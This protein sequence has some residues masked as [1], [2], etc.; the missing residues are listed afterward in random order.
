MINYALEDADGN[1]FNI[2]GEAI[3]NPTRES[4]FIP[5]FKFRRDIDLIE[6]TY[7]PGAVLMNTPRLKSCDLAIEYTRANPDSG[8][9]RTVENEL[10][11]WL[12]KTKYLVDL[13]SE[14]KTRV[15][16]DASTI[17]FRDGSLFHAARCNVSFKQLEPFWILETEFTDLDSGTD[18]IFEVTNNGSLDT[19]I[20]F[21]LDTAILCPSFII[22]NLTTGIGIAIE[23][24]SFGVG[25]LDT[26]IIDN[27][28]G[29]V[30]LEYILRMANI[31]QGTGFFM[32]QPGSNEINILADVSVDVTYSYFERY[33]V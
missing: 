7:L 30:Y 8:L 29:F 15:E 27:T 13:D 16:C 6:K 21:V 24:N 25:S 3:E 2:N 20:D 9:F 4:S 22:R 14:I 5:Q 17:K 31:R 1:R 12:N 10:L 23:D 33:F 26:Y 19:P 11:F 32:L 18:I 28:N